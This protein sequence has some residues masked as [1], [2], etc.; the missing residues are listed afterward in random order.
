MGSQ[1]ADLDV[2][3]GVGALKDL[4]LAATPEMNGK[5]YNVHVAG[6]EHAEGGNQYD[7]A[8]VPW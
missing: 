2:E 7:G 4:V 6:W 8:E 3:T 1:Y 5:F